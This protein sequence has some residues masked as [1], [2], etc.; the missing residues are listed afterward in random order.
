MAD[1][2]LIF[3]VIARD[4]G[5]GRALDGIA[6][7]FRGVGRDAELALDRAGSGT[8]NLDRQIEEAQAHVRALSEEFERTG[9]KTLFGKIARDRSL[10]T[11]LQRI[12]QELHNTGDDEDR[13]RSKLGSLVDMF[14]RAGSAAA[15]FGSSV[16]STAA[17]VGSAASS[18]AGMVAV[19]GALSVGMIAIA[20]A[21]YAVGGAAAALPGL[22]SG[23]IAALF[24]LKLGLSGLGENWK[25]MNAPKAGGGGGGGA[26]APDLTPKLRAVEAA[27]RGVARSARDVTDA[28]QALK[29]AQLDVAKAHETAR[30]RLEDLNR[31][32]RQ[33]QLDQQQAVMD[34][35][36]ADEQLRLAQARGNPDE[37]RKAQL[38]YDRQ[39]LAVEDAKDKVED[40]GK[41]N[42]DATR[43]GVEGSDEVVAAR[44]REAAAQ[45]AVQDSVLA[46]QLAIQQLG[47]AQ[48]SLHEKQLAAAASGAALAA[49]LPKIA[50]SAQ[51]FL[52]KL[53]QLK[54]AFDDL[55][56]DIQQRLFEGLAGKL[57]ILA[58]RWLPALR[59]GLGRMADTFND[60]AKT[61]FDSLS[62]PDFIKN[63]MVGVEAF[64]GL[65]GNVGKAIAGPL[66]DAWGR[67]SR[68][69]APFVDMLGKKIAGLIT[70]FSDWIARMDDSGALDRFM[71]K[72]TH[73]LGTTF[74]LFTD[75]ARIAG[76]VISILFGTNLGGTDAWDNLAIAVHNVADYLG[77]PAVQ[78]RMSKFVDFFFGAIFWIGQFVSALGWIYDGV[79]GAVSAIATL[80]KRAGQFLSQLPNIMAHYAAAAVNQFGYWIGYGI[81]WVITQFRNLPA[82]TARA[83]ASLPGVFYRIGTMLLDAVGWI[84]GA[85]LDVGRNIVIGI[86]NGMVSLQN[87][88]YSKAYSFAS[89]I[90]KGVKNALGITSPSKVMAREVGQWIPAGIAMGID[91]NRSVALD[92]AQSIADDMAGIQMA[93][94]VPDLMSGAMAAAEGTLTLAAARQQPTRVI[95]D[96]HGQEGPLKT[97]VRGMARTGNLYQ[98]KG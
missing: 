54:P 69:S 27:Q 68:A 52:D 72:A 4:S 1:T 9:D 5:V 32:Y 30:E 31:E 65:L 21:I 55:R 35:Q 64:R 94:P 39:K 62:R 56:L 28:Q 19:V 57:Q 13:S 49:Q 25:A 16:A 44:K 34:L 2:S 33:S 59:V 85:M 74:D 97:L 63:M 40:L 22:L 36:E 66:V 78:A 11:S 37:I 20:P 82:N 43:K 12:R 98:D 83:I 75:L 41:E 7:K 8:K 89:S 51:A 90:W 45:R 88:L 77:D 46:H 76:D 96:V 47:D 61:A 86:W 71:A 80:P 3:N 23:A 95:L 15:G 24:T 92:A 18:I 87:W 73:V 91:A 79:S 60:I 6:G 67:L 53:K 84:Y 10:I 50:A 14:S 42:A 29:D 17:S 81:G 38:A 93:M 70:K 26:Q 58:D 48:K